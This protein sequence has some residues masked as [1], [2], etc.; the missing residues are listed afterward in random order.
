V[1]CS[2]NS[3]ILPKKVNYASIALQGHES[4]INSIACHPDIPY[5]AT[6]GVEKVVRV[7]APWKVNKGIDYGEAYDEKSERDRG[8]LAFFAR[9]VPQID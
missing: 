8:T 9:L 7:F 2:S 5:I 3:Y 4:V 1:Y 6:A